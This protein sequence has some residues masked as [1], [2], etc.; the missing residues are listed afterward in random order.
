MSDNNSVPE[1][2][3]R[4]LYLPGQWTGVAVQFCTLLTSGY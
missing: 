4:I 1:Q 2:P 3:F